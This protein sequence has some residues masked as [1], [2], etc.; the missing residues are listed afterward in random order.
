ML[1]I[2]MFCK[3]MRHQAPSRVNASDKELTDVILQSCLDGKDVWH[4][5]A[6]FDTGRLLRL[7]DP[8]GK[9]GG[10]KHELS[11]FARKVGVAAMG[12]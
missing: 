6:E 4:G 10:P 1:G 12:S 7:K 9:T 5:H 11:I 8:P 3:W 2:S